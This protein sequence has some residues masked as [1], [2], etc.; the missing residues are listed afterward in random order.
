MTKISL[1]Q[2]LFHHS[3]C[4]TAIG[5]GALCIFSYAPFYIYPLNIVALAGL[6]YLIL[7]TNTSRQAVKIAYCFGLGFFGVG[8]SWVYVSLHDFGG[9]PFWMAIPFTALFCG[10]LA[11]FHGATA[12]M[13]SRFDLRVLSL[14]VCWVLGEWIRSWIFTGF[15]WL[16]IGYAH[17][18]ASPLANLAPITGVYG[19]SLLSA[20]ISTALAYYFLPQY[21]QHRHKLVL[22][23]VIVWVSSSV[24][25]VIHWTQPTGKPIAIALLQGN[26]PQEL[27][28]APEAANDIMKRYLHM[29]KETKAELIVMPESAMPMVWEDLPADT[30]KSLDQLSTSRGVDI[31]YGVIEAPSMIHHKLEDTYY[32]SM[33][34][35]NA[36]VRQLYRKVHLVPFGEFIPM[37]RWID[38]IYRDWLNMPLSDIS[39]G[40]PSQPPMK[41]AG[42]RVG[43]NICYEDAFGE[44]IIQSLPEANL[45]VNASNM[46]WFGDSWAADQHLQMSQARALETGRVMLRATNT[47]ATAV[48]QPDGEITAKLAYHQAGILE[49]DVQPYAGSTP[50]S[51]TGNFPVI[52]VLFALIAYLLWRRR[53]RS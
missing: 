46:A 8:V 42:I 26:V 7:Q 49:A 48:I 38:F 20:L 45:L 39:R 37:K 32:N 17:I 25:H 27:K 51:R 29:A 36:G 52:G 21:R 10:F 6:F 47:G 40:E 5:L 15:P 11:L 19:I 14:P 53:S 23:F 2:R 24:L 22:G 18:P 13:A 28:W 30:L 43:M 44:E 9:M 50:Y 34:S 1:L 31:V 16:L 12:W 35:V 33:V 3:P 41:L 4:L